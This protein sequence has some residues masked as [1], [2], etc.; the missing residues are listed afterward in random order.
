MASN[1]AFMLASIL[2]LGSLPGG[3]QLHHAV[4]SSWAVIRGVVLDAETSKPIAKARVMA[5]PDDV[6]GS[7]KIPQTVTDENG[8]FSFDQISPGRY[9]IAAAKE[10]DGYPNSD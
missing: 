5:E 6:P 9:V 4:G 3:V 8:R 7:T 10:S 2:V 1:V